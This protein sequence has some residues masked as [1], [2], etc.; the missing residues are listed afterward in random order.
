[1]ETFAKSTPFNSSEI[2]I[3]RSKPYRTL[4]LLWTIAA[5][6]RPAAPVT[7]AAFAQTTLAQPIQVSLR[8]AAALQSGHEHIGHAERS[9]AARD[10]RAA[11]R[12]LLRRDHQGARLRRDGRAGFGGFAGWTHDQPRGDAADSRVVAQVVWTAEARRLAAGHL[13]L[14]RRGQRRGRAP[15]RPRHP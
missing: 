13:R 12:Q 7:S 4:H 9:A 2:A 8:S 14:H 5:L 10:R 11:G 15:H 1:M 6:R 3:L